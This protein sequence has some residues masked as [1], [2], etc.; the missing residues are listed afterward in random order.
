[1][2]KKSNNLIVIENGKINTYKL[3]NRLIWD[4]GRVSGNNQPDIKCYSLTVSR[5]HGSFQNVDGEW[6]YVD[7]Y[8]KNG[9]VYN[10]KKLK[11]T[12][13]GRIKTIMLEDGDIFVFGGG[14]EAIINSKTV[15]ALFK[16][17]DIG[18]EWSI[19]DTKKTI[20]LSF[21]DGKN[22]TTTHNIAKGTVIES[23]RGAAI[24]MGEI[25]FLTG[26]MNIV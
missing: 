16:T 23:D 8:G 9:T 2:N 24:Y 3:D 7:C 15:W 21:S 1:M 18:D 26:D 4:V 25:T 20:N 14:E 17:R 19:A 13:N 6:F 11:P 10:G 5:K 22:V 12:A